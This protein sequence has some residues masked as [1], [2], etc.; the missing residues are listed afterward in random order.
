MLRLKAGGQ[1]TGQNLKLGTR[2]FS[3]KR[4]DTVGEVASIQNDK[5]TFINI[6]LTQLQLGFLSQALKFD[7]QT[8]LSFHI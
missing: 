1:Y 3:T 6:P 2:S 4:S 7:P 8:C 5:M